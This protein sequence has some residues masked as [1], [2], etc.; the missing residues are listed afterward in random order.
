LTDFQG[1]ALNLGT[2]GYYQQ[3]NNYNVQTVAVTKAFNSDLFNAAATTDNAV[4]WQQPAQSLLL[5]VTMVNELLFVAPS[6]TD[7]DITVGDGS[8]D[9]GIL[10]ET[11]NLTSDTLNTKYKNRGVYWNGGSA[12]TEYYTTTAKNWSGYATATGANLS[13]LTAG[14]V[15]FYFTY[16][17]L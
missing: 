5:N 8:D 16:R 9:N 13:T 11:M 14:Q 12:G 6:M 17:S 1:K 10:A 15:T 4:L 3:I 7:L 2:K